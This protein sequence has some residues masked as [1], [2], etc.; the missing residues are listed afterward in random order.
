MSPILAIP[1]LIDKV[2][3]GQHV[4]AQFSQE[5]LQLPQL[6]HDIL[7]VKGLVAAQADLLPD[8]MQ[9]LQR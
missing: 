5:V 6:V 3:N 9:V 8:Q 2:I 4:A 7:A 1:L